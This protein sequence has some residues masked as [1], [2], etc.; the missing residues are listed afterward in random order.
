MKK[1]L[2]NTKESSIEASLREAVRKAGGLALKFVSPGFTGVP[3]RIIL[4]PGGVVCFVETKSK[5]GTLSPRQAYVKKQF[6]A[7]GF[8]V[9]II[10]S[11]D[12]IQTIKTPNLRD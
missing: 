12:E 7:L 9:K 2:F 11:K 3:D 6:E 5:T 1:N 8:E 4:F 10:N